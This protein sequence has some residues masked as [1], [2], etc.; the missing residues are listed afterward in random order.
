[1]PASPPAKRSNASRRDRGGAASRAA[2]APFGPTVIWLAAALVA[3]AFVVYLPTLRAELIWD[4]GEN[5]TTNETLRS[6]AGLWDM[7]LVPESIQQYYPLMYTTYWVEYHLWEL[8]PFGYHLD[9]ILLHATAVLLLWRLLVRLQVPGAWLAA[10]L[11]AVH[12]VCV[13]S[14]A[15]V[16]ERKNVLSL[17]LA[18]ASMLC[19]LRYSPVAVEIDRAPDSK[20]RRALWYA[21]AFLLF[22]L[23][24]FA[25]T[26]VV[27]LPAV[28]LVIYWWKRG[29]LEGREIVALLP[30][31]AIGLALSLITIWMETHHV[32]AQG[33][34]WSQPFLNRFLLAGRALWFYP[35]KLLWPHPL[36][37]LYPRWKIDPQVWWQYLFPAAALALPIV[38][39]LARG[40]IGRGP[41]AAVLIFAGVLF[42][43]LG[44]FNIYYMRYAQVADHFQYHSCTALFALAA[45]GAV[46]AIIKIPAGNRS[47]VYLAGAALL[48]ILGVLSY[49][50]T[51]IYQDIPTLLGD[52]IAKNPGNWM[53]YA[54][55]ADH[56]DSQGK[57]DEAADLLATSIRLCEEDKISGIRLFEIR[58]KRGFVLMEAGRFDEADRQFGAAL[59]MRPYDGRALFGQGMALASQN[60]F[61]EAQTKFEKAVGV[62]H[63][64]AEGYYGLAL[65]QA[66]MGARE[67][68]LENFQKSLRLDGNRPEVHFE[69]ANFLGTSGN[70]PAAVQ[71]Y[72]A[73]LRLQPNHADALRNIGIV[74]VELNQPAE[75]T[76]YLRRALAFHPEDALAQAALDKLRAKTPGP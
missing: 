38:L 50:Q 65:V 11:F 24:L 56:V 44:F 41:L 20:K 57:F 12:P 66:R 76:T 73:T 10:A 33:D 46:G 22:A 49:R 26:M 17:S 48:F 23:A 14:V 58:R 18:L 6:A 67:Q 51:F 63:N 36:V 27:S 43:S 69:L 30:F 54:N 5:I 71:E 47:M 25:K 37:F 52:I 21:L 42:P 1:M 62:D 40:R 2:K 75:A 13:E 16:T 64:Y 29:R 9:N 59:E 74:L 31:F 68:A 32:G 34:D 4:D 19:Y 28:L 3:M 70:L 15:W 39:W 35:S 8:R 53:P 45:A 60:R 55:L 7:W 61:A 72:E